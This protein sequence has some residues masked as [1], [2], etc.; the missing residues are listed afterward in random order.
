MQRAVGWLRAAPAACPSMQRRTFWAAYSAGSGMSTSPGSI[1]DRVRRSWRL[2]QLPQASMLHGGSV[3][4][5]GSLTSGRG[6][7][8]PWHH[9]SCSAAAA[10]LRLRASSRAAASCILQLWGS[11]MRQAQ[12]Q[13]AGDWLRAAAESSLGQ[14]PTAGGSWRQPVRCCPRGRPRGQ[15][16]RAAEPPSAREQ[17]SSWRG[18]AATL[19]PYAMLKQSRW[20]QGG[21][22]GYLLDEPPPQLSD[23]EGFSLPF[24]PDPPTEQARSA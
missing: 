10:A 16:G 22:D 19:L 18:L 21:A 8:S 7:Q 20:Q 13:R 1:C 6:T 9:A 12:I 17:T 23:N 4:T 2:Q 14:Q 15:A 11:S 5:D 24:V 3:L